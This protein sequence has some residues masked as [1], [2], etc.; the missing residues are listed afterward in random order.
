VS[1]NEVF[2][3]DHYRGVPIP[4]ELKVDTTYGVVI[5]KDKHCNRVMVDLLR[6]LG[7]GFRTGRRKPRGA[8]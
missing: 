1:R 2:H 5:R 3:A 6:T 4:T 8:G 7:V